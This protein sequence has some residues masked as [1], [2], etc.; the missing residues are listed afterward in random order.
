MLATVRIVTVFGLGVAIWALAR[1][2]M[3]G[4]PSL[5]RPEP[6][7]IFLYFAAAAGV[8]AAR[9]YFR[10]DL[11]KLRSDMMAGLAVTIVAI[12]IA[13]GA[14]RVMTGAEAR[15]ATDES[16]DELLDGRAA[17]TI[18]VQDDGHF[19]ADV[20]INGEPVAMLVDTGS[21]RIALPYETARALGVDVDDL[22]FDARVMT[23]NGST[24]VALV[25]LDHVSIGPI[26]VHG[27]GATVA[28]PGRL[29]SPL[30]GMS[31]LRELDEIRISGGR[32]TMRR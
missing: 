19:V 7:L 9:R 5:A 24:P 12:A 16:I 20:R 18:L 11:A 29:S 26:L 6:L 15:G 25:T 31:F 21:S 23:A 2:V 14:N 4:G 10:G 32:M 27:V 30:L 13:E 22:A 3:A 8:L 1:D 28:E 17:A